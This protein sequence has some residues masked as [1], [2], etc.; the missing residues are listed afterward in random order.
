M[1]SNRKKYAWRK[2][3]IIFNDDGGAVFHRQ[4]H[5][6]QG[7]LDMRLRPRLNTQM[8]SIFYCT[9]VSTV[10]AHK[11]RVAELGSFTQRARANLQALIASGRDC[12]ELVVDFAREQDLEVFWSL[13]I[14]DVHDAYSPQQLPQFKRSHPEWLLGDPEASFEPHTRDYWMRTAMNFA[15]QG[16]RDNCF[17]T[18]EEVA[19]HYDVDGIELDFARM[20]FLFPPGS[21]RNNMNLLTDLFRRIRT[22]LDQIG[23]QRERPLLLAARVPDTVEYCLKIGLDIETC[24][25]ESLIDVLIAGFGYDPFQMAIRE[26]ID[27][28]HRFDVPVYPCLTNSPTYSFKVN[29]PEQWDAMDRAVASNYWHA[30]CDGIYDFNDYVFWEDIGRST[31]AAKWT[32]IGDPHTL[33]G[34]NK[35]YM[36]TTG[37]PPH[38]SMAHACPEPLLPV[39]LSKGQPQP[40]AVFVGDDVE[41]VAKAGSAQ[42]ALRLCLQ[43][44]SRSSKL[45]CQLNGTLLTACRATDRWS[46]AT[47]PPHEQTGDVVRLYPDT[48]GE[49]WLVFPLTTPTLRRGDNTVSLTAMS[50]GAA[51]GFHLRHLELALTYPGNP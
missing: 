13:R 41:K 28:G 12:L 6:P 36:T 9:G 42:A 49:C 40:V 44:C 26:L 27:L 4:A 19:E 7:F 11:T 50:D 25:Q 14:N 10:F 31:Q 37:V 15:C 45:A 29:R 30:S 8:D 5:T 18:V 39:M 22:R 2:R 16:V 47:A 3:R 23:E 48:T 21:E 51:S 34:K 20:P 17:R 38:P 35:L 24:L 43:Q 32:E 33:S 46:A 1:H